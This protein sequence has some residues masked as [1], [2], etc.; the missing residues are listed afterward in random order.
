MNNE[1]PISYVLS[2]FN[3]R[4]VHKCKVGRAALKSSSGFDTCLVAW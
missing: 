1:S 2:G 4:T 3:F